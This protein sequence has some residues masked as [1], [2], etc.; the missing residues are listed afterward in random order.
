MHMR[1]F[2]LI[3]FPLTHSFSPKYFK[4]K[5]EAENIQQVSYKLFELASIEEVKALKEIG[6]D[7]FNVTIPYKEQ[8]LPYL[9]GLS[10]EAQSIGAVNT[11]KRI[12]YKWYG[13]NTDVYGFEESILPHLALNS[14]N[15]G[16]LVLGTGG[17]SKAVSYV[18]DKL[19]FNVSFV[20][21]TAGD[22]NY[23]DLNKEIIENQ[24]VIVNTTPLGMSP[25][26]EKAPFIPYEY[27]SSKH[28]VFDLIYNPEKTLFLK[29]AEDQGALIK[30][31]LEMLEL[32]AEK[33]WMIWN[34]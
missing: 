28:L 2:G 1:Q 33:S 5:F 6:V 22:F 27:L 26:I 24:Y 21:R 4:A 16:A 3:G 14:N 19:G 23:E 9:D 11:V 29:K 12:G 7:G 31:G 25:N 32:Q 15:K 34:E 17:A 30:N 10:D 8:I 20:S 13:H 18:L